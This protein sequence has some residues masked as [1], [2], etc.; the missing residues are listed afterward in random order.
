MVFELGTCHAGQLPVQNLENC[1]AYSK[2]ITLNLA[3]MASTGSLIMRFIN[4]IHSAL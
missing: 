2:Y 4:L 3:R 1:M